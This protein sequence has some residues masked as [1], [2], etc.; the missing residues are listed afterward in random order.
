MLSTIHLPMLFK[1]PNKHFKPYVQK[2][3]KMLSKRLTGGKTEFHPSLAI[4]VIL[5][6]TET[7]ER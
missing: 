6:K 2:L 4:F 1:P 5:T 7:G 3:A